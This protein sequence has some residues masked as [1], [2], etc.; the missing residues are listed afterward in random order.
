SG[1]E[2]L[3]APAVDQK[4]IQPAIV[5][6]IVE[7][8]AATRGLKEIFVLVFAAV[9]GFRVEPGL[10]RHVDKA[11]SQASDGF[12]RLFCRGVQR[13]RPQ[14]TSQRQDIVERQHERRLAQGLE[15][16]TARRRQKGGTFPELARARIRPY[17]IQCIATLQ[18]QARTQIQSIELHASGLSLFVYMIRATLSWPRE[19]TS[20]LIMAALLLMGLVLR[21]SAVEPP[22]SLELSRPVR[23]WEFLSS[24]GERAGLLGN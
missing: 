11:Q 23:P 22:S 7:R 16:R 4:N 3:E 8:H 10:A 15:K 5:V 17:S 6:I 20:R 9:D 2:A 12:C 18:V 14:R 21:A 19:V 13:L 1:R 24:V